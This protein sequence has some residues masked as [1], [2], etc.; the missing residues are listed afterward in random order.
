M[1][2]LKNTTRRQEI[3][4]LLTILTINSKD[5]MICKLSIRRGEISRVINIFT[6]TLSIQD[7][8]IL[9]MLILNM[10]NYC[11]KTPMLD[12]LI[13]KY[14]IMRNKNLINLTSLTISINI[15]VHGLVTITKKTSSVL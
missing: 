7:L 4:Q 5:K 13:K 8:T 15:L 1:G 10:K 9:L 14:I 12:S 6:R 3:I 11:K 2:I